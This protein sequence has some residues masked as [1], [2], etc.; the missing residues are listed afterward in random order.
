MTRGS[1]CFSGEE[2]H[3]NQTN[4]ISARACSHPQRDLYWSEERIFEIL[5]QL[6]CQRDLIPHGLP[7]PIV[8]PDEL[9]VAY[10]QILHHPAEVI[11]VGV[12]W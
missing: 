4:I 1:N 2:F 9:P 10:G 8:N 7:S 12:R 3:F 5:I 6:F 11:K